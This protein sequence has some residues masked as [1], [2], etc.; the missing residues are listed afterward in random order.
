MPTWHDALT[1]TAF[2]W[3][4][5]HLA[6]SSLV[7]AVV[8]VG[9]LAVMA[10]RGRPQHLGDLAVQTA[11]LLLATFLFAKLA[12]FNEYYVAAAMLVTGLAGVGVAFPTGDVALPSVHELRRLIRPRGT[13]DPLTSPDDKRADTPADT[14][15]GAAVMP[16]DAPPPVP[17][18]GRAPGDEFGS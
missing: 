7:T 6:L 13:P 4:S 14:P 9:V 18:A 3:Q 11:V 1:F 15:T 8:L 5:W 12:L 2:A 10:W 16:C 17:S